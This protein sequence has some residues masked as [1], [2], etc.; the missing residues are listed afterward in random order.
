LNSVL[1]QTNSKITTIKNDLSKF[2]LA[3]TALAKKSAQQ[4][5]APQAEVRTNDMSIPEMTMEEF[6]PEPNN[7]LSASKTTEQQLI[8][9]MSSFSSAVSLEVTGEYPEADSEFDDL[10]AQIEAGKGGSDPGISYSNVSDS[11]TSIIDQMLSSAEHDPELNA[12]VARTDQDALSAEQQAGEAQRVLQE[13]TEGFGGVTDVA[14]D[15]EEILRELESQTDSDLSDPDGFD[16]DAF[17]AEQSSSMT[18]VDTDI[19]KILAE[20]NVGLDDASEILK[21]GVSELDLQAQLQA[22]E[23]RLKTAQ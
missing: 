16:I 19:M 20:V 15:D 12:L 7:T 6:A 10:I 21:N 9:S 18:D 22:I 11:D 2:T 14:S 1:A 4:T 8:P 13:V 17:V 3:Q 5:S 23:T